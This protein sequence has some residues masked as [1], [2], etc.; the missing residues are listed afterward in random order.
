LPSDV[1][2]GGKAVKNAFRRVVEMMVGIFA[3]N[4]AEPDARQ[5][6]LALF[7]LC[8]GA[9]VIARAVDDA[10]LADEFRD[11]TRKFVLANTGWS[12]SET[13]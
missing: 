13:R 12:E 10:S 3:A 6:A 1:A 9:M 5:R 11:S 4:L 8:V 2:R 7:A